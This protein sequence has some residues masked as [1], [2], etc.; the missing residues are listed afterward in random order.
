[1]ACVVAT[2]VH[3]ESPAVQISAIATIIVATVVL[4]TVSVQ[5]THG[6]WGWNAGAKHIAGKND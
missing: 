4:T 3:K 5:K 2:I 1:V 6:A